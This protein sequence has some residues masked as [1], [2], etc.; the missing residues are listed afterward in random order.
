[1]HEGVR[2][3]LKSRTVRRKSSTVKFYNRNPFPKENG[4]CWCCVLRAE[5]APPATMARGAAVSP[6]AK[7]RL[8][9]SKTTSGSL[10]CVRRKR[11]VQEDLYRACDT[12]CIRGLCNDRRVHIRYFVAHLRSFESYSLLVRCRKEIV[13]LAFAPMLAFRLA[14]RSH[15]PRRVDPTRVAFEDSLLF[16]LL[17]RGVATPRTQPLLLEDPRDGLLDPVDHRR[18]AVGLVALAVDSGA[19]E[20]ALP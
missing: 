2:A 20:H 1:M 4:P 18:R 14:R 5:R 9:L 10:S 19:H 7:L 12:L 11:V 3:R 15:A 8:G 17:G 6:L 16:L 13:P